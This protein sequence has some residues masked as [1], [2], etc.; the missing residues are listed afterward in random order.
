MSNVLNLAGATP[1]GGFDPIP[2]AR[3]QANVY[4]VEMIEVEKADGK[5]PLGT[6]G[7][8]V[9]FAIDGGEYDNRRLWRRYYFPPDSYEKA[10]TMRDMLAGF[11]VAIGY[12]S[13]EVTSGNF[14]VNPEDMAGR[15]CEITVSQRTYDGEIYND[16]KAV[17]PV[18]SAPA[19]SQPGGGIL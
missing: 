13:E 18:G 16:V 9:Q 11:F 7:I 15:P 12:D 14:V 19:V 4:E 10:A 1:S 5:L 3:Y 6:P 8:S 2:S 17:R